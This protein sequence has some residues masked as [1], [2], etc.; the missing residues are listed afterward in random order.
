MRDDLIISV[1]EIME[2]WSY[3]DP[4][5]SFPL[6]PKWYYGLS[7]GTHADVPLLYD[8]YVVDFLGFGI[9]FGLN[10]GGSPGIT[11]LLSEENW[12]FKMKKYPLVNLEEAVELV[13]SRTGENVR[14]AIY[15]KYHFVE[16]AVPS[17]LT[18]SNN[19]YFVDPIIKEVW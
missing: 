11:T 19:I 7:I 2:H 17:I 3:G 1:N 6:G 16:F 5:V 13:E 18:E 8:G 15:C 10:L 12:R 9:Y 14:K 4:I